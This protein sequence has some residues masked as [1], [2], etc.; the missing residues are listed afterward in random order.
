MVGLERIEG[1]LGH[2]GQPKRK[3]IFCKI[4]RCWVVLFS[5]KGSFGGLFYF[6][7]TILFFIFL[8]F[9][10]GVLRVFIWCPFFAWEVVGCVKYSDSSFSGTPFFSMSKY[11]FMT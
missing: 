3:D 9:R 2:L 1:H 5:V 10:A 6:T 11:F 8:G 7:S 4:Y